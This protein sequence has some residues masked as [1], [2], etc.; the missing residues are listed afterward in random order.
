MLLQTLLTPTYI[1]LVVWLGT[2]VLSWLKVTKCA[3]EGEM[4]SSPLDIMMRD[5]NNLHF[6][7]LDTSYHLRSYAVNNPAQLVSS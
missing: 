5:V 4:S 2:Y 3:E 6:T 1:N 7:L